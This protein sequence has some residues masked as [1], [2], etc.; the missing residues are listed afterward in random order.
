MKKKFNYYFVE[1]TKKE[2][3]VKL[4]KIYFFFL[5]KNFGLIL[6]KSDTLAIGRITDYESSPLEET[7]INEI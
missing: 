2:R 4:L 1:I 5:A 6:S 7:V 3:N